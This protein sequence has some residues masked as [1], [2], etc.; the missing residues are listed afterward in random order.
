MNG[1]MEPVLPISQG[2]TEKEYV[3]KPKDGDT[4]CNI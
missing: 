1:D 4:I 2:G 3:E